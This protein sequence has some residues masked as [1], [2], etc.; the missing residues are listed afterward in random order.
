[1][2]KGQ[3]EG[4]MEFTSIP[5]N[6]K[7]IAGAKEW[8]QAVELT[9]IH[10]FGWP[11]GAVINNREFYPVPDED[12]IRA[13]IDRRS[14]SRDSITWGYD[15]WRLRKDGTFYVLKSLFEDARSPSQRSIFV[16]TRTVRTA[17][18]FLRT[19]KL[20]EA[21]GVPPDTVISCR[22]EYGG[23]KG[24]VLGVISPRRM[25]IFPVP[26]CTGE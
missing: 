10:T 7:L 3:L 13:E 17:E 12:G 24:R 4:Y 23:L 14:D 11:I 21:L 8:L 26:V 18:V 16:D 9:Q 19:A 1:M 22:I 6:A 15:F 20:Y 5:V 2:E 25:P